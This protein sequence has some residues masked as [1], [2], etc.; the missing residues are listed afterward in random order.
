MIIMQ[1]DFALTNA[2]APFAKKLG[3]VIIIGA[4]ISGLAAAQQ[5]QQFGMEVVVLE[6]RVR[7]TPAFTMLFL[8]PLCKDYTNSMSSC[9]SNCFMISSGLSQRSC[10]DRVGGRVATFR[11][12]NYVADLGAMVVTGLE[13]EETEDD[14]VKEEIMMPTRGE[15]IA[16]LETLQKLSKTSADIDVHF[17]DD[18]DK[19]RREWGNPIS[20]LSKQIS[21]ELHKIKQKCPLYESNGGTCADAFRMLTVAYGEATLDRSNVYRWYKMFSEGRE[22]VNDEERA[23]R[24]ST[25]TT[26]EKINQVEKM[27]LANHRITVREVAEDLNISIGLC[28]SIFINDLGMRRVTAKFVPKLLNC[29]QKQHRMNIAN[30]MLDSVRDD[31]NLLQRVI[32][33]DEAW[34]YGYDVEIKAQSSQWKLLH[35]PRPKKAHQVRSNGKVLLTVFFDCRGVVHHEFL[36]QGRTV[37]KEYYLQVMCNLREAICQKRPDLWKNKNWLLHHDNAPAHTSLLVRDLFAKNNTLMMP[38]PPYSPDLAPCDFFLFPKLKRPMKGRR[39]AMLD[40]I[41]M[42]SKEELKK[43]LKNDF[44]KCFEDWKNRWHKC[45]IS[46]GHYFEGDK[47]VETGMSNWVLLNTAVPQVPKDKDEMVEREFNRLLESTSYLSHQLDFNYLQN[48]PVS[49][50]QALEW[51]IKLQEKHVKEKQLQYWRTILDLQEKLK[52]NHTRVTEQVVVQVIQ[53]KEKIEGLHKQHKEM[54]E[55]RQ[56]RDITQEF[57]LRCKARELTLAFKEYDALIEQQKEIED[58]LQEMEASPPSDVYLSSRDRQVLDWHFANLEFANATPLH[59]LSLKHW[60]QDDDFEFTGSHLTVRNG[61]SCVPVTMAEGLDIRLSTAVKSVRYNTNGHDNHG[62]EVV[63]YNTRNPQGVL[64]F[65]GDVVL[66]TL[67]L[68]VL[69]Q[70]TPGPSNVVNTVQFHPPLPDWKLGAIQRLGFGNLNKVV[71]CFDRVFWDPSANLFGHVGSTTASRGELFLFWNLYRAPVL[72]ALVAGEAAAIM[73][74]V[75]DDVIVGRCV[76]VLKGIFGN[77]NVPHPKETVVTRWRADPWSRGSYS[78]V[79]TGSSGEWSHTVFL[80]M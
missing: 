62:V 19:I 25:S 53:T 41:K 58:K 28:H 10:L 40:E 73:E 45:I 30:E 75:S 13:E 4:G 56:S 17:E 54:A 11:K 76:A 35:E 65:K 61:Y 14:E 51:V 77:N 43:I 15:V 55:A 70:I 48:K 66:C 36:P 5:L 32:T 3:K 57:A 1:F 26:D 78:F 74:N 38:Q 50:G 12:G 72:L 16:A 59:T 60:D 71:L 9:S 80:K 27:I 47:I 20:V 21:M 39:Y 67:P 23:G 24:P 52:T 33:G 64:S 63:C 69:K 49:L 42:A 8:I 37:N 68:G 46:H 18:L 29:D 34:V 6:A 79:A 31:P 7:L 22:D 44:L 2:R